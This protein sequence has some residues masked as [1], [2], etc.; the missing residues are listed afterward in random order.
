MAARGFSFKGLLLLALLAAAVFGFKHFRGTGDAGA[1]GASAMMGMGGPPPV[2]VAEVVVKPVTEWREFSGMLEAVKSVQVRPRV[3]GAITD[4]HFADGE[5]V[6]KGEALFT[7]DTRPYAAEVTRTKGAVA[8]ASAAQVNASQEFSRAQKLIKTK[9]ISQSEYEMKASALKQADGALES[10]RGALRTAEVNLGYATITAPI[11]GK[12]SRAEITVGNLVDPS[13]AQPLASIVDLSPIYA[14]FDVDEQTFIA[15]I[16]GK[17]TAKL[18]TIPV[19]VAFGNAGN[20]AVKA[21]IHSFDNQIT[22]G[23]GTIRVR[24]LLVNDDQSLVPG[25]FAKVRLG[26]VE[27]AESVM[28][29]PTAV[30]T[31]QDKKFVLV[32]DEKNTAQYRLVTLGG[33]VDGLQVVKDGL[34]PGEKI[35]VNG[36]QRA[37]PGTEVLPQMADMKT[38]VPFEQ[39]KD[40][41]AA[42]ADV[43]EAPP[44]TTEQPVDAKAAK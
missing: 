23:S 8:T 31:D 28:I 14:S 17:P 26:T 12:I 44:K 11:S 32:V 3:G 19:E 16:Q 35:V 36:L 41:K 25:L 1:G 5:E 4:I 37:R 27:S 38:L 7:I 21:R 22:P 18:K 10:A 33:M 20:A 39:P 24:A 2:G 6:K 43:P 34:K 40:A 15:A 30:S 9:A 42:P 29:H 13:M